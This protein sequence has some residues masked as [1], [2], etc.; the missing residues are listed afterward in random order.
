MI[1]KSPHPEV[2]I[3]EVSLTALL[4]E[5]ARSFAGKAALI[6]G[7]TG[8]TYTYGQ[9]AALVRRAAAGLPRRGFAQGDVLAIYSPNL[10]EYAL[11]FH[12]AAL[13]GGVSTTANPT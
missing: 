12:G 4:L 13:A 1:Q 9:W 2:D 7:P 5:R 11:A 3:P 6:D 10:P 8:R